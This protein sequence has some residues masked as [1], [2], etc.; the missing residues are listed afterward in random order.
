MTFKHKIKACFAFCIMAILVIAMCGCDDLGAYES[1]D[2]YYAS[3]GDIVFLG[4][5]A[6]DGIEYPVEDYFYNEDSREDFLTGD[7][8]E[9]SGVPHSDYVYVAIPVQTDLKMDSLAMYLQAKSNVALYI[10]FYVVDKLPKNWKTID[11]AVGGEAVSPASAEAY[12]YKLN[13]ATA[14][15]LADEGE[16]ETFDDPKPETRIGEINVYLKEGEW[17]SFTL[18]NFR[19]NGLFEKTIQIKKNQYILLQIRNNSGVREFDAQTGLFVDPQ[20]GFPLDKAEIT[21]TNLLL[22]AV[23]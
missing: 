9:Y 2:E 11:D 23:E 21:M 13:E 4:G 15:P 5:A 22:R 14:M 12:E 1:T 18:D 16:A 7:D 17:N 6:K 8:G 19:V 3:F 20:S 10:N